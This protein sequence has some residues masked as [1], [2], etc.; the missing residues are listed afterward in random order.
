M[1]KRTEPIPFFGL[2]EVDDDEEP[3]DRNL[4]SKTQQDIADELGVTR[5]A[6]GDVER[7][8]IKKFR[9]IFLTKFNKDDFI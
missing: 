7:R 4:Y 9:E 1:T 5:N 2:V 6:V 3:V 8:A